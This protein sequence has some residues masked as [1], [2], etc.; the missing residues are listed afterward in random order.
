M[1][2]PDDSVNAALLLAM[3]NLFAA[4]Y[5]VTTIGVEI[6]AFEEDKEGTMTSISVS[7]QLVMLAGTP[8]K[9]TVQ[10]PGVYVPKL[11]P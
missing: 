2:G 3:D 11:V 5:A 9:V 4:S 7:D 8:P 10:E 1:T 6:A